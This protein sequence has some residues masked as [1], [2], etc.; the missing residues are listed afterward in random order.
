MSDKISTTVPET[1]REKI[2]FGSDQDVRWCPG[3]GDYAILAQMKRVLPEL[4]IPREKTV[5]ISGIGCSSRF[6]YYIN[7]YGFHTVHGRAPALATGVKLA[8]PEL[9]VWIITGDGDS[10]SIGGN[11]LIHLCRRNLDVNVILFNNQ[12]YGLTKGQYSPT[13]PLGKI[14][15]TTPYGSLD[16]PFN[17]IS[18]VL[19][20]GA[21]FVARTIDR[22]TKHMAEIFRR[23][24]AHKGCSFVEVY[25][26]CNIFND[27]A[28]QLLTEQATKLDNVLYLEEGK[29]LI[30]GKELNHGLRL[31]GFNIEKVDL[32]EKAVADS[33]IHHVE[34]SKTDVYAHLLAQ[35][36]DNPDLPTPVGV[37]RAVERQTYDDMFH[38]QIDSVT[39]KKGKGDLKQLFLTGDTWKVE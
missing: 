29:P 18:L 20:A 25:Q 6:P 11:H 9:S 3:C 23:A 12:I 4:G 37:F 36:T 5:F 28:Y 8:N 24:A 39:Q 30:Y 16:A 21:S 31:N 15:K 14:T 17:P 2:D 1:K 13:S 34:N 10:L 22:D 27:G 33:L 32:G 38:Q 26:N 7:S 19:S 35:I